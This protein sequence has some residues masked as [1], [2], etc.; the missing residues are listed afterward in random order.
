MEHGAV[1]EQR[2]KQAAERVCSRNWQHYVSLFIVEILEWKP[3]LWA[4]YIYLFAAG[5]RVPLFLLMSWIIL[6]LVSRVSWN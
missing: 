6:Q 5:D 4:T 3:L 1:A 2:N